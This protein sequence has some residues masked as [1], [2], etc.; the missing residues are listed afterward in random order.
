MGDLAKLQEQKIDAM[1]FYQNALLARP[2][3]PGSSQKDELGEKARALW[4]DLGGTNEGWQ[5]WF[6]RKD[7]F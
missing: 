7:L 6:N 2:S 1:T 4:R 3:P 5:A